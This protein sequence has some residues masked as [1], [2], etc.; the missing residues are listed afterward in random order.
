MCLSKGLTGGYLPL[1][2]VLTPMRV[3]GTFYGDFARR[4]PFLHS[5]SHTGNPLRCSAAV[6]T[7]LAVAPARR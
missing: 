1:A 5:H 4:I 3:Y 2:A 6:A 7:A